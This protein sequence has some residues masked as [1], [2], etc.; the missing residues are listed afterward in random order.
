MRSIQGTPV[1]M[2]SITPGPLALTGT[3][4]WRHQG[5]PAGWP[6]DPATHEPPE[7]ES[8]RTPDAERRA[9]AKQAKKDAFAA[10]LAEGLSVPKAS[11]RAGIDPKTGYGYRNELRIEQ[12][13][14]GGR[15]A[16][17]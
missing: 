11:A 7:E 3:T 12:A 5:R 1:G 8:T 2:G 10:A 17:S 15:G 6:Y 13:A 14:A 4:G 16:G 9:E